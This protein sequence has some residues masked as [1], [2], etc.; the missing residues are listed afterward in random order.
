MLVLQSA[1][2]EIVLVRARGRSLGSS[3]SKFTGPE[4]ICYT[5]LTEGTGKPQGNH[6]HLQS[7]PD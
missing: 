4:A 6:G 1:H 5:T 3:D 2:N 7:T